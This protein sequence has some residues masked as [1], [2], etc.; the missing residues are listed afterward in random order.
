MQEIVSELHNVMS[1]EDVNQLCQIV[2]DHPSIER[3]SLCGCKDEDFDGY[4]MLQRI[5]RAGRTKLKSLDLGDNNIRTGGDTFISDFL[6]GNPMLRSLH[7]HINKLD[8]N[9]AAMIATALKHNTNLK[10]L[11]LQLNQKMTSVGWEALRKAVFDETSLN[12]AADSNHTCRICFPDNEGVGDRE[13]NSYLPPRPAAVVWYDP[14]YVRKKK[15]YSILSARNRTF[16]NVDHFDEN[17]PVEL[18]PHILTSI[19]QYSNYHDVDSLSED[20]IRPP[21]HQDTQD[22]KPLSIMFEILQRWDKSLANFEAL[23][24]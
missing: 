20:K 16:S 18:L 9:D 21:P 24:S 23:N 7:L 4:D 12:S 10:I 3:L 17:M 2:K 19:E 1:S 13:F 5:M 8:D 11:D 14:I 6:A 15:V 22:V